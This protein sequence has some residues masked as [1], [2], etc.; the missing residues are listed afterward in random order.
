MLEVD[1]EKTEDVTLS[2]G[3]RFLKDSGE[4]FWEID[5][6]RY[7]DSAGELKRF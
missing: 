3:T 2:V 6:I 4:K 7:C 1:S 5:D